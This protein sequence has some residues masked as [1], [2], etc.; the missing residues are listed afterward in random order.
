M[1]GTARSERP[2]PARR[3]VRPPD[4]FSDAEFAWDSPVRSTVDAGGGGVVMATGSLTAGAPVRPRRA[5]RPPPLTL[6]RRWATLLLVLAGLVVVVH[7]RL[8]GHHQA[9]APIPLPVPGKNGSQTGSDAGSAATPPIKEVS[10]P[11]SA[12]GDAAKAGLA[13][14]GPASRLQPAPAAAPRDLGGR[15]ERVPPPPPKS[16]RGKPAAPPPR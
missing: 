3:R 13:P 7:G 12:S 14:A 16:P 8:A 4:F 5:R 15:A 11:A 9:S 10:A 2:R 1:S 6:A